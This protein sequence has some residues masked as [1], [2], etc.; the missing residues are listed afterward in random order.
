MTAVRIGLWQGAARVAALAL[1]LA[2]AAPGTSVAQDAGAAPSGILVLNQERL[3]SASRFGQRVAREIEAAS[4]GLAAENRLIEA[5]LTEEELRLTEQR[6]TMSAEDFRPLADEFDER[7]EAIRAAQ[8]AK[9][10]LLT[11]QAEEARQLFFE[12][13]LPVLLEIIQER[14]AAV[15]LDNRAILLSAETVDITG[16]ALARVN[17]RLGDGG[18]APILEMPDLP[19][20]VQRPGDPPDAPPGGT[21][22]ADDTDSQ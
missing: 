6:A 3:F 15:I 4:Q 12:L 21:P 5:Q 17:A 7:V 19:E 20:P 14:D 8:D 16:E 1:C 2:L 10:R 9:A 18:D 13:A 22:G 11:T